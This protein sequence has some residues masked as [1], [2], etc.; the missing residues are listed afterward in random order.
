MPR[1]FKPLPRI[2]E[3]DEA[4][5]EDRLEGGYAT[6]TATE[7]D[8]IPS[9]SSS[10]ASM[11]KAAAAVLGLCFVA[12]GS[13]G[14]VRSSAAAAPAPN[15][16]SARLSRLVDEAWDE[17]SE[18]ASEDDRIVFLGKGFCHNHLG[19]MFD[20]MDA[21]G[22]E[23]WVEGS[24]L[25]F[26]GI[27]DDGEKACKLNPK[28]TGLQTLAPNKYALITT[29]T[30]EVGGKQF[31]PMTRFILGLKS[32]VGHAYPAF[33]DGDQDGHGVTCFWRHTFVNDSEG[34]FPPEP[35]PV[36]KIMWT[37]W[38]NRNDGEELPPLVAYS[39]ES[40]R[41]M[42]EKDGWEIRV[43]NEKSK[44]DWLTQ[45]DLPKDYEKHLIQHKADLVRLAVLRKHGG[46]WMDATTLMLQPMS[47]ILGTDDKIRT[48]MTIWDY[49]AKKVPEDRVGPE[50]F[51]ENWFLATPAH[52]PLF[53]RVEQCVWK[54]QH[55]MLGNKKHW[56]QIDQFSDVELEWINSLA[57]SENA[58]YIDNYLS[59]HACFM[60]VIS[61]DKAIWK[62]YHSDSVR[63]LDAETLAFN[64]YALTGWSGRGAAEIG[65]R[66]L[67]KKDD[68]ELFEQMTQ[69]VV[70]LMKLPGLLRRAALDHDELTACGLWC[71]ETTLSHIVQHYGLK[72][73][74]ECAC[75]THDQ[76]AGTLAA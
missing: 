4:A 34:D 66:L 72:V 71:D 12:G 52:D 13:I 51:V 35:K 64:Y 7:L 46:V 70:K 32:K 53:E 27:S 31:P 58:A 40:W 36:A 65:D 63:H 59:T 42:N 44:F 39:V 38:Q 30:K 5:V 50:L 57:I 45:E 41:Q 6:A 2:S 60:K 18:R 21:V 9:S 26:Q 23:T 14:L 29:D 20:G 24:A 61:E 1:G 37:F 16:E 49:R 19:N 76:A 33:T 17:S 62:W 55:L 75:S 3:A 73:P 68:K 10:W 25:S 15:I 48:F 56:T 67:H 43:L 54:L 8:A 74:R 11:S 28:C 22:G 47:S 69:P